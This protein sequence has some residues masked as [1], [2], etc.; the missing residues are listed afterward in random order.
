MSSYKS[1]KGV[2]VISSER[3][4]PPDPRS[5]RWMWR[6]R[7]LGQEWVAGWPLETLGQHGGG[8]TVAAARLRVTTSRSPQMVCP[9]DG[10]YSDIKD[11]T[12][13]HVRRGGTWRT[14]HRGSAETWTLPSEPIV[15]KDRNSPSPRDAK[16]P[17]W[18]GPGTAQGKAEASSK[19]V[20]PAGGVSA[21]GC[22]CRAGRRLVLRRQLSALRP[23]RACGA[24]L[25]VAPAFC[26]LPEGSLYPKDSLRCGSVAL[27]G[28]F[29][30]SRDTVV[31]Y[32][33][34]ASGACV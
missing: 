14:L 1:A 11:G 18:P 13:T 29:G 24:G 7:A 12:L 15:R 16:H 21:G 19:L 25:Q 23:R 34:Q 27:V 26:W 6:R 17:R 9:S 5:L 4:Q 31:L 10:H 2:N 22:G 30:C 20:P 3:Q 8:T 33:R 32:G 28:K